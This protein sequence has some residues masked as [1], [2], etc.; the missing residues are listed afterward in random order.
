MADKPIPQ[1]TLVEL[2]DCCQ[3]LDDRKAESLRVFDVRGR[4]PIADFLVFATGNSQPHL[5]ALRGA[6]TAHLKD[7]STRPRGGPDELQS[8][9]I[10][11]DAIDIVVHLFTEEMRDYYQLERLWGDAREIPVS[12]LLEVP[13]GS[14]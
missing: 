10:V 7:W 12:E 6:V 11:V 5:R 13:G 4:S 2:H 9:W 1:P 3:A 8:G 14:A